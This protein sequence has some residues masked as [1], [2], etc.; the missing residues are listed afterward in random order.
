MGTQLIPNSLLNRVARRFKVLSEPIR[1][2][3]LNL[4][5]VHGEMS[6]MQLVELSGQNQ[7][8]VSKHLNM[9]ARE[10][11]L[12]R[13]KDGLKVYYKL[14]DLSIHGICMLVCGQ[15]QEGRTIQEGVIFNE[16]ED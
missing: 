11:I 9:M 2:Q 14:D 5:M 3:I 8:N 1:L 4:L 10:G 7:A 16:S 13:R 15:L 12:K 6:V